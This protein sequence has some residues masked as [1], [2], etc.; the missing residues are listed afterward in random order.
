MPKFMSSHKLPPGGMS[1]DQVCQMGAAAAQDA[2]VKP[3]RSFLNLKEGKAF[4]IIESASKEK[5]AEWFK[6]VGMPF[7]DITQVELEGEAGKIKDA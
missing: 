5:V 2:G 6:K 4:C 3:Y 7:D 1:K